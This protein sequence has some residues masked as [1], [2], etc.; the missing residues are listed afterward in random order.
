[1]WEAAGWQVLVLLCAMGAPFGPT[2]GGRWTQHCID[3]Y[4]G[5]IQILPSSYPEQKNFRHHL[6]TG[7]YAI[8]LNKLV[9]I[10]TIPCLTEPELLENH[11][12]CRFHGILI[13]TMKLV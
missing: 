5:S 10:E 12:S 9:C 13:A 3:G 8:H 11:L 4:E 2:Y 6:L 7:I 1:M